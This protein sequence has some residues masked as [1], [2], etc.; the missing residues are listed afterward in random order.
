MNHNASGIAG[1]D[2]FR[3]RT[4]DWMFSPDSGRF[5]GGCLCSGSEQ[6]I[7]VRSEKD[8]RNG[9]S[10]RLFE[11]KPCDKKVMIRKVT[12]VGRKSRISTIRM[13]CYKVTIFVLSLDVIKIFFWTVPDRMIQADSLH[14][15]NKAQTFPT[16]E[17]EVHNLRWVHQTKEATAV[18]ISMQ[19]RADAVCPFRHR[20]WRRDAHVR[21]FENLHPF[22]PMTDGEGQR[23]RVPRHLNEPSRN[24]AENVDG[25]HHDSPES[26][27]LP[28]P[29]DED[30]GSTS[31]GI[32]DSGGD[33]EPGHQEWRVF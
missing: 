29:G 20:F 18:L 6:W 4:N 31:E 1:A 2:S 26:S 22:L 13:N 21:I 15:P 16:L 32:V 25:L 8:F 9:L 27:E 7:R 12:N 19:S 33:G 17:E 3:T 23:A 11:C 30:P 5:I 14:F 28:L 24:L 10:T